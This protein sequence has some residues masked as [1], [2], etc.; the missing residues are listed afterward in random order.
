MSDQFVVPSFSVE[1]EI[2]STA[3]SNPAFNQW[4]QPDGSL[5]AS[6]HHV[7]AG[8]LVH[9]PD[10]AD[11]VISRDGQK[12]KASPWPGCTD[13]TIEHLHQNQV[14]PLAYT[15]QGRLVL[16]GSAVVIE[17]NVA[18]FLGKSGQGKSTL[19]ASFALHGCSFLTDDGLYLDKR[20]DQFLV[21]PSQP[22]I[23]LW[24][25]SDQYLVPANSQ[26]GNPLHYT[27]KARILAGE[28]FGFCDTAK[29]LQAVYFLAEDS[30]ESIAISRVYGAQVMEQLIR[31]SFIL[32]VVD[33]TALTQHF[34]MLGEF[35]KQK[36][37][38]SLGYP[39]RYECLESVRGEI[40]RHFTEQLTDSEKPV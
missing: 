35:A 17:N 19:A 23:R 21:M 12:I 1:A 31:N 33:R 2:S 8:Y 29:P 36:F 37:F 20:D 7:E 24:E 11:F 4:L 26:R 30:S 38:F 5:W 27:S 16:H 6:F 9:F 15:L 40:M 39:K 18:V 32:D 28:S 14:L 22:A 34:S 3:H 25:D 13:D 10:L